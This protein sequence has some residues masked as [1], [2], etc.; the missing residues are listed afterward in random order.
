MCV[1]YDSRFK[2]NIALLVATKVIKKSMGN[3]ETQKSDVFGQWNGN[4]K[5]LSQS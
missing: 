2:R 3:E 4:I 1:F 5:L